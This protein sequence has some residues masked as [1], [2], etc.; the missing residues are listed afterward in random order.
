MSKTPLHIVYLW[1]YLKPINKQ[2]TWQMNFRLSQEELQAYEMRARKLRS[3]EF[4]RL[5]SGFL[6][7]FKRK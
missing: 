4:R 7:T 5:V 2:R 1:D 3:E 6:G